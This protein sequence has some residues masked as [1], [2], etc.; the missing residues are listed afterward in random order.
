[1][2]TAPK[3]RRLALVNCSAEFLLT[4]LNLKHD[5]PTA[6]C[7]PR[8]KIPEGARVASVNYDH[9][10]LCF[11][12]LLEHASFD[13]VAQGDLIPCL[14]GFV[15]WREFTLEPQEGYH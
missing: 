13:P 15:E 1:M 6:V 9:H 11:Q 4:V 3:E 12:L 2:R 7:L 5:R 10:R 8:G 14:P